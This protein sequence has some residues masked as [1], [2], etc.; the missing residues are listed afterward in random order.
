MSRACRP[1]VPRGLGLALVA[2]LAGGACTDLPVATEGQTEVNVELNVPDVFILEDTTTISV[3]V[4]DPDGRRLAGAPVQWVVGPDPIRTDEFVVRRAPD[5]LDVANFQPGPVRITAFVPPEDPNLATDTASAEVFAGYGPIEFGFV[6]VDGDTVLT[7]LGAGQVDVVTRGLDGDPLLYGNLGI[8]GDIPLI[9]RG[10]R[11]DPITGG[12]RISW[13]GADQGTDTLL[14]TF[15]AC[16]SRCADTLVFTVAPEP[17]GIRIVSDLPPTITAI[18]GRVF[19]SALAVDAANLVIPGDPVPAAWEL[20]NPADSL[21]VELVDVATGRVA[22]RGL[23]N[24]W[25]TVRARFGSFTD[26]VTVQVEQ[27]PS[28]VVY[29]Y[30]PELILGRGTVDSVAYELRDGRGNLITNPPTSLSWRLQPFGRATTLIEGAQLFAFESLD[31][32]PG[33][34]VL[35]VDLCLGG[36]PDC[37][38][39]EERIPFYVIPDPDSIQIVDDTNGVPM[40]TIRAD[41]IGSFGGVSIEV[42]VPDTVLSTSRAEYSAL[43]PSVVTVTQNGGLVSQ[44]PGSGRVVAALG[45]AR[46]TVVVVVDPN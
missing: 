16:I 30:R 8:E 10:T 32:G 7:D 1:R 40:D 25:A 12:V 26:E 13:T 39:F 28:S 9:L 41:V 44:A 38:P 34:A 18:G 19:F 43:D 20:V 15:P 14:V 33:D 45:S 36:G 37:F 4:F 46:D 2:G 21:I 11:F 23:A 22:V 3:G 24:G 31:F 29:N 27:R 5:T 35:R 42:F 6:G 17:V